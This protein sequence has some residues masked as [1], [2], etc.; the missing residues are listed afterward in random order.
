MQDAS[1]PGLR[2][3]IERAASLWHQDRTPDKTRATGYEFD[4]SWQASAQQYLVPMPDGGQ[5]RQV[6]DEPSPI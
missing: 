4:S 2:Q 1:A 5:R 3:A 6:P